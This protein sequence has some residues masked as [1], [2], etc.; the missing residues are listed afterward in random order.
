MP[1]TQQF[2]PQS[3]PTPTLSQSPN[4]RLRRCW[5]Q[6]ER[7]L[8]MR[9][10]KNQ[11]WLVISFLI[12]LGLF[13]TACGNDD[14]SD[15]DVPD[16][17]QAVE[18]PSEESAEESTADEFAEEEPVEDEPSAD[19]PAEKGG[20]LR[21]GV[22]QDV[23]NFD[24]F[25]LNFEHFPT[26]MAMYDALVRYDS[27][28]N[29]SPSLATAWQVADDNSSV[30][31]TLRDGATFH[32]GGP[33]DADAVVTT[34][35]RAMDPETGNNMLGFSV[36]IEAVSAVDESTVLIEF[37]RPLPELAITDILQAIS[38]IDPAGIDDLATRG[39]GAG[40]FKFESWDPG[41]ELVLSANEN[42]WGNR[43]PYVAE[44]VYTIFDDS[45]AQLAAYN[46]GAI[47]IAWNIPVKDAAALPQKNV[48]RGHP[49]SLTYAFQLN[50]DRP[51]FDNP[52]MRKM[53]QFATNRQGMV[54]AAL[55]GQSTATVLPWAKSSPAYDDALNEEYAFDLEQA[56]ELFDAGVAEGAQTSAVLNIN[57]GTPQMLLMGQILQADLAKIGFDMQ[58]NS[59]DGAA[60]ADFYVA[61]DYG[62]ITNFNG[63]LAKYPTRLTGNSTFRLEDNRGWPDGLPQEYVDAINQASF[64]LTPAEQEAAFANLRDVL[65][66]LS[67]V[68]NIAYNQN[69]SAVADHV[70][71]A[72]VTVDTMLI[73]EDIQ[74]DG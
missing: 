53:L 47:D 10:Q 61:K 37:K 57:S 40:P 43:G 19:K 31:V 54:D 13:A 64:A 32:S 4:G 46:S 2:Q 51:P 24:P 21:I 7:K 50:A 73:L 44:I 65:L 48:L 25:A 58:I 71:G 70:S 52:N 67:W 66:D 9:N 28:L 72:A 23:L 55:F 38:I 8:A 69:T 56:R 60:F 34:Y 42:Y 1:Q 5:K 14:A 41:V 22:N 12:V 18:Q 3:T 30:T 26:I 74:L 11:S 68:I 59:L 35:L 27:E 39:A 36:D 20:T 33:V 62:L 63:N 49:G 16:A 15:E 29:V 45:D 17:N 6:P